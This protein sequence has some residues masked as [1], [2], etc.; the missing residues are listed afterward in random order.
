MKAK[1]ENSRLY[2]HLGSA[3]TWHI[4]FKVF[5]QVSLFPFVEWW[6]ISFSLK[7]IL[8]IGVGLF[9]LSV[10]LTSSRE[11]AYTIVHFPCFNSFL[12][13]ITTSKSEEEKDEVA[14][15]YGTFPLGQDPFALYSG[16]FLTKGMPRRWSDFSDG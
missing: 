16:L 5:Y 1:R 12:A 7:C 6:Y 13:I 11:R 3:A 4:L 10:D 2:E 9:I 8:G 15:P 14:T